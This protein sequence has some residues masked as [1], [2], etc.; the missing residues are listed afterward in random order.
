MCGHTGNCGDNDGGVGNDEK[1]CMTSV[2]Y[3]ECLSES[4]L[5][6]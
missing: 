3:T 4:P 5:S 1:P 2:N 6:S